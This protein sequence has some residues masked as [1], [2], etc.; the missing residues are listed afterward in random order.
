MNQ[1]LASVMSAARPIFDVFDPVHHQPSVG[2]PNGERRQGLE[3]G[4]P[5]GGWWEF[6]AGRAGHLERSGLDG[7]PH[8]VTVD[9][10]KSGLLHFDRRGEIIQDAQRFSFGSGK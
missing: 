8:P 4:C 3:G 9:F 6:D 7:E 2:L 5:S 10:G 1:N